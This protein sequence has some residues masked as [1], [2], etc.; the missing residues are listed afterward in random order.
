[1]PSVVTASRERLWLPVVA[2]VVWSTHFMLCYTVAALACGRFAEVLPAA[3]VRGVLVVLTAAAVAAM[4][5]CLRDGWRRLGSRWPRRAHDDDHPHDRQHFMAFTTVLLAGL[6]LLATAF[7]A[8][9]LWAVDRC[10]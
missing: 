10:T 5:W 6:S 3:R 7:E 9:A 8:A 1:M 4:A 2:P